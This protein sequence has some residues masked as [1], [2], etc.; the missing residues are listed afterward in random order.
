MWGG[1]TVKNKP[2]A[3]P[4]SVADLKARLHIDHDDE[5]VQLDQMLRAAVDEI[6]G[7]A[8]IG[9][10][11]MAQT[12]TLALDGF[13]AE[14]KLPGAPVASVS[15]VRY[16]DAAGAWQVVDAATYRLVLGMDPAR[17]V[18]APG[19][20]WPG[21]VMGRAVVEIDYALG[22]AMAADVAPGLVTAVAM[23]AGHYYENRE[24][25]LAGG[26][27]P[28]EVPLG[29]RHILARYSRVGAAA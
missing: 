13:A 6:D 14:I 16:L 8:G 20:S 12:W 27:A 2:A 11:M 19:K 7:P 17:L 28:V 23:L 5:D 4:L 22:E 25:V 1:V 9:F 21:A 10:A 24:A 15:E 18:L 29:V 26:G 3:L